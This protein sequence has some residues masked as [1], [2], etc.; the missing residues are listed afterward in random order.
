MGCYMMAQ[1]EDGDYVKAEAMFEIG[2]QW[3][4][5]TESELM[6]RRKLWDRALEADLA[7]EAAA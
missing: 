5:P 6:L 7:R 1:N 2:D 4:P 3:D